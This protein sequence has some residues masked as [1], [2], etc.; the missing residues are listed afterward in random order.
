MNNFSNNAILPK[1][2]SINGI[3]T[4]L[5][6]M[7]ISVIASAILKVTTIQVSLI[8]LG[9]LCTVI[10]IVLWWYSKNKLGLKPNEYTNKD[11]CY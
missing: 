2:Y 11:I 1:I 5:G 10:V 7:I 4:N 9:I 3:M 6:K 8:I